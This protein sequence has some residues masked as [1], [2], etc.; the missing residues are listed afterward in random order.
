MTF[1]ELFS[2][3]LFFVCFMYPFYYGRF[4]GKKTYEPPRY[5]TINTAIEQLLE[6]VQD[7]EESGEFLSIYIIV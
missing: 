3:M 5:M 2:L 4:R 1:I 6:I 7:R